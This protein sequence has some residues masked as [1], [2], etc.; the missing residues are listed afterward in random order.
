MQ[1][2]KLKQFQ[3]YIHRNVG[4]LAF[5]ANIHL[6]FLRRLSGDFMFV[7]LF[8]LTMWNDLIL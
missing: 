5:I 2:I 1:T 7:T 4:L 8:F 3:F 6:Q